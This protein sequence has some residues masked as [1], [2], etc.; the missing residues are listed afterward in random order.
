TFIYNDQAAMWVPFEIDQRFR[1][2]NRGAWYLRVVGRLAPGASI[3]AA[4]HEIAGIGR[5]LE[6]EYPNENTRVGMTIEPLRSH[7]VKE[8]RTALLILLGAVGFVLLIACANVANLFLAR[9]IHREGEMAVRAA[10]GAGR[11]RLMRQLLTE[12]VLLA[13]AG[14]A[15]GLLLAV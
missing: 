7:M 13:L 15:L 1:T 5:Q 2:T 4:A 11:V 8:L 9:A 14:G 12:S 10:L 3:E 6:A